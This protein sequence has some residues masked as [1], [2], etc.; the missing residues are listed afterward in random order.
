MSALLTMLRGGY[1]PFGFFDSDHCE[2]K[3]LLGETR[4]KIDIV[5]TTLQVKTLLNH[6][7]GC[8][9]LVTTSVTICLPLNTHLSCT[10]YGPTTNRQ[11]I[12]DVDHRMTFQHTFL[13]KLPPNFIILTKRDGGG[14]SLL[15]LKWGKIGSSCKSVGHD[16]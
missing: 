5:R 6:L 11:D 4:D 13:L 12:I 10:P 14:E 3:K 16:S 2:R 1:L 8:P 15:Q 7:F 9:N